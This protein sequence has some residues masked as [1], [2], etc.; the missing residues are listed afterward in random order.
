MKYDKEGWQCFVQISEDKVIKKIKTKE[1]MFDSIRRYLEANNQLDEL[2]E[3]VDKINLSTINSL[4]I[5]QKSKIPKKYLANASIKENLIEQDRIMPLGDK[6]IEL[7]KYRDEKEAKKLIEHLIDF[8]ITLWKYKIHENTYKFYSCYGIDKNND[9]VLIDFLEITDDK[10]K[11]TKQIM[12][13][14]WD[15]PKRYFG[16]IDEKISDYFIELT[17]RRLTLNTL[18]RNWGAEQNDR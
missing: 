4:R 14:K 13:K 16:K 3:K 17:N 5:I 9:I 18:E 2:E 7:I 1:E 12:D 8:I 15:K 6:I 11:V 10:E